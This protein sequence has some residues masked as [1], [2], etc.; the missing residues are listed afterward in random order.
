MAFLLL[1]HRK[2]QV[3]IAFCLF[4][5]LPYPGLKA[6]NY[7]CSGV[8]TPAPKADPEGNS[9]PLSSQLFF[10]LPSW[11]FVSPLPL[12]LKPPNELAPVTWASSANQKQ[13]F[14]LKQNDRGDHWQRRV[15]GTTPESR[16]TMKRATENSLTNIPAKQSRRMCTILL[17]LCRRN[18]NAQV[19]TAAV[20]FKSLKTGEMF[21]WS[22]FL[23]NNAC[24][25]KFKCS[26]PIYSFPT[27]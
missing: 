7:P 24:R 5:L 4:P 11:S 3:I 22:L 20:L 26:H 25:I 8:P 18:T 14:R 15:A 23:Q 17:L 16:E 12:L 10:T 13:A 6:G 27:P 2:A 9:H 1:R 21:Q 19:I